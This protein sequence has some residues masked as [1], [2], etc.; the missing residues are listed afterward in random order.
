MIKK[1]CFTN[2]N[3][4]Q[5]CRDCKVTIKLLKWILI[6]IMTKMEEAKLK[7]KFYMKNF[8]LFA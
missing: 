5:V 1:S 4:T 8:L 3:F 2:L 7:Q 6:N